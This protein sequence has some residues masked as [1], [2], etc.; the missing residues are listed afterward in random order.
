MIKTITTI[1]PPI[2][3]HFNPKIFVRFSIDEIDLNFWI[4]NKQIFYKKFAKCNKKLRQFDELYKIVEIL[5]ERFE[6]EK[7]YKN[8][9]NQKEK[10][11]LIK[12]FLPELNKHFAIKKDLEFYENFSCKFWEND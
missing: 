2:L 4:E 8:S 10:E 3:I 9:K 12:R 1:L 11:E 7:A 6:K 5:H